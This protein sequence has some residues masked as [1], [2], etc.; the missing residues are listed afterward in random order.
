MSEG[1]QDRDRVTNLSKSPTEGESV[2][3]CQ[4]E[5]REGKHGRDLLQN[6]HLNTPGKWLLLEELKWDLASALIN[7]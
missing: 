7:V 6:I 3:Q 4:K 5:K 2:T 1:R